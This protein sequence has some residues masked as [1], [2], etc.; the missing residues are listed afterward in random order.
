MCSSIDVTNLSSQ[1]LPAMQDFLNFMPKKCSLL[2][3]RKKIRDH[4]FHGINFIEIPN[5]EMV[6]CALQGQ[7]LDQRVLFWS[8]SSFGNRQRY[9][10]CIE[11]QAFIGNLQ[12]THGRIWLLS[13]GS[14]QELCSLQVFFHVTR[15]AP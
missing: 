5:F 2:I 8:Q 15:V 1:A 3:F 14:T 10:K 12:E 9:R 13:F 4:I 11:S 7:Q 6:A